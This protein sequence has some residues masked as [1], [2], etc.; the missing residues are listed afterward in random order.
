[1]QRV[2]RKDIDALA[3]RWDAMVDSDRS[4]DR[5]CSSTD[6]CLPVHDSFRDPDRE[7]RFVGL[8][9]DDTLAMFTI[10]AVDEETTALVGPDVVWAYA[11]A[12]LTDAPAAEGAA[13]VVDAVEAIAADE[14][15]DF[16]VFPGL[17]PN[18]LLERALISVL[19]T[20]TD[21][22]GLG[23]GV[24]RCQ[25]MLDG[26]ADAFL[27]RRSPKFRRN[28]RKA[29][30]AGMKAGLTIESADPNAHT[31]GATMERIFAVEERSWKGQEGSGLRGEEMATCFAAI[32]RRCADRG[33]ARV[34][35]AVVDGHDVGYI[36]GGVRGSTY[37]GLQISYDNSRR[38]LSIGHLL[39]WHEVQRCLAEG[40]RRYDLGMPLPYKEHWSDGE[41]ITRSI[42]TRRW[43]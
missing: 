1:V 22:V 8:V 38:D 10:A 34:S 16:I 27:A 3:H 33:A 11:T 40:M 42:V 2:E 24:S 13:A 19:T 14:G 23:M 26:D 37:R 9:N 28:L 17:L 7:D 36:L 35:F 29:V 6:W 5:W 32:T 25:A 21:Q 41:M 20:R 4:I 15:I 18:S 39:Q 30:V 31:H 12:M 43:T